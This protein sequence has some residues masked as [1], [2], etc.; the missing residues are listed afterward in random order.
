[1]I[2]GL[3]S[4]ETAYKEKISSLT[5]TSEKIHSLSIANVV[6]ASFIKEAIDLLP[7][8]PSKLK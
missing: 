5:E 4:E 2:M 6:H 8:S 1:M 3:V 7:S